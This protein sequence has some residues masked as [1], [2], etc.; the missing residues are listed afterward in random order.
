MILCLGTTPTV[1]RT[2]T[3]AHLKLDAVNRAAAVVESASGKSLNVAR[4]LHTLGQNILAIGFLGADSGHMIRA[5]LDRAGIPHD[6]VEVIPKTRT[7]TTVIDHATATVTELVEETAPVDPQAYELLLEIV[8][9]NLPRVRVLVLS[10][11]LPPQAPNDFYARCTRQARQSN[12]PVILDTR[13]EPLRQALAEKPTLVKP[14]R[15]EL[16]ETVSFSIDDDNSLQTAIRELIQQGP[17]YAIITNGPRDAIA[18]DGESFW[19]ITPPKITAV[20]PIGS[21]DAFAAGLAVALLEGHDLP[22][23]CILGTACG[24]ANALNSPPGHGRKIDVDRLKTQVQ[25]TPLRS[26]PPDTPGGELG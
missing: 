2:M 22:T 9:A 26:P 5:D 17:R 12:I 23:A 19:R 11:S 24:A 13:G 16:Q 10:G 25:L 6:F 15:Q 7:C 18:S 3:F 14:N 8:N 1:Q 4:T 21:G 20:N